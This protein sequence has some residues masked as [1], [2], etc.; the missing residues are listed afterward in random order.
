MANEAQ[1][2]IN[3]GASK[4]G[5]SI[6]AQITKSVD[7]AANVMLKNTQSIG[8]VAEAVF[9]GDIV[10]LGY[11]YC[12]NLDATNFIDLA[13]DS[14]MTQKFAK[15]LGGAGGGEP[16]IWPSAV[17]VIYARANTAACEMEVGAIAR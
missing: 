9:I 6:Q 5:N 3:F 11:C 10:T 2:T 16:A 14:D 15:L 8:M 13:L 12:R 1:I 17:N 4:N 7:M